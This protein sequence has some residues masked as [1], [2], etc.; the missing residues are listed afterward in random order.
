MIEK[1][2]LEVESLAMTRFAVAICVLLTG[3][4]AVTGQETSDR[5][6]ST[7]PTGW[8]KRINRVLDEFT[9]QRTKVQFD[10]ETERVTALLLDE[11]KVGK[12]YFGGT[13]TNVE[14]EEGI[15][16]LTLKVD[17]VDSQVSQKHA[18][19]TGEEDVQVLMT[20]AESRTIEANSRFSFTGDFRGLVSKGRTNSEETD[21]QFLERSHHIFEFV[22]TVKSLPTMVIAS[23]DYT[24]RIDKRN[25]ESPWLI[26][27]VEEEEPVPMP[28]EMKEPERIQIEEIATITFEE[29]L[30]AVKAVFEIEYPAETA[31]QRTIAALE[32]SDLLREL[33]NGYRIEV[34]ATVIDVTYRDGIAKIFVDSFYPEP[35]DQVSLRSVTS[36]SIPLEQSEA[37]RIGKDSKLLISGLCYIKSDPKDRTIPVM[38]MRSR[39]LLEESID[40]LVD[41]TTR[42]IVIEE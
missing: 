22:P 18:K 23:A 27:L 21:A 31:A 24:V 9:P 33:T 15:A 12:I 14:W 38:S 20:E 1:L 5:I 29:W 11:L 8:S 19:Y 35:I 41:E 36:F 4:A 2:I 3:N 42:D 17:S 6:I 10:A 34:T 37:V 7:T 32:R 25:F 39:T 13:V 30:S 40:V 16:T 28:E 26:P